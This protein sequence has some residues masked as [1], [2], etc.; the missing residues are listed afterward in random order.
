VKKYF[1]ERVIL[2]YINELILKAIETFEDLLVKQ[3]GINDAYFTEGI[4]KLAKSM[5]FMYRAYRSRKFIDM[6]QIYYQFA[7]AVI[8]NDTRQFRENLAN[9]SDFRTDYHYTPLFN[10]SYTI[11][12]FRAPEDPHI[13]WEEDYGNMTSRLNRLVRRQYL[14]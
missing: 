12:S 4:S 1:D 6:D 14:S 2:N 7:D 5:P 13:I 11:E 3:G 8:H 9:T 10:S